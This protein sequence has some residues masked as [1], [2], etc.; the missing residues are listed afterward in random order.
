MSSRALP[1]EK[2]CTRHAFDRFP[3]I[4]A[5]W[6]RRTLNQYLQRAAQSVRRSNPTTN[7][8]ESIF[9]QEERRGSCAVYLPFWVFHPAT[10]AHGPPAADASLLA[11]AAVRALHRR[12]LHV[13]LGLVY[14][15]RGQDDG[16]PVP[17]RTARARRI[18][19]GF[20][21]SG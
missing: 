15:D 13:D 10:L 18:G 17:A 5:T 6:S 20:G 9:M 12:L 21:V 4:L 2:I 16:W 11:R 7:R 1:N 19:S 8:R 14:A 3:R